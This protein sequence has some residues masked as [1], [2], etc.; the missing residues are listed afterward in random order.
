MPVIGDSNTPEVPN[1]TLQGDGVR[2][3]MPVS[4]ASDVT[5]ETVAQYEERMSKLQRDMDKM[6]STYDR[7]LAEREKQ[8]K[9]QQAELERRL[10]ETAVKD[11]DEKDRAAYER[12]LYAQKAQEYEQRLAQLEAERQAQENMR[13]YAEAYKQTF[14]VKPEDLDM[15]NPEMFAQ[16]AWQAAANQMAALRQELEALKGGTPPAP[17]TPARPATNRTVVT[18]Q[19]G[20]PAS[21]PTLNDFRAKIA[22]ATGKQASE[23]SDNEIFEAFEKGRISLDGLL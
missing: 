15:S 4:T 14:G 3:G 13:Q 8:W 5:T 12:D 7:N 11:L 17:Q 23:V 20:V 10:H 21:K 1:G 16:S 2:D 18:S 6:R 19:G 22:A 9:A